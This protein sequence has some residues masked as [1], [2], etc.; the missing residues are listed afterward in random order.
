MAN[1]LDNLQNLGGMGAD[2]IINVLAGAIDAIGQGTEFTGEQID[3]LGE[4]EGQLAD[5]VRS[6]SP[7]A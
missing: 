5:K 4:L 7:N 3:R 1:V 6:L 2:V